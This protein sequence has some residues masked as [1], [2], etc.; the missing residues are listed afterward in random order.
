[1]LPGQIDDHH[2]V[3][4]HTLCP[5]EK[6]ATEAK[7]SLERWM[8]EGN[9][10]ATH[11]T[12]RGSSS[13]PQASIPGSRTLIYSGSYHF[14]RAHTLQAGWRSICSNSCLSFQGY[15][16]QHPHIRPRLGTRSFSSVEYIDMPC[17]I[18]IEIT[19]EDQLSTTPHYTTLHACRA[20]TPARCHLREWE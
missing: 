7:H 20:H 8:E 2:P 15:L 4:H 10:T 5:L 17:F 1:M 3:Y 19:R 6:I 9:I 14:S 11:P 18:S 12:C 16:Y 13:D